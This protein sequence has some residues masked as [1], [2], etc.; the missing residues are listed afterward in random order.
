MEEPNGRVPRW[1]GALI[2]VLVVGSLVTAA[3]VL[4]ASWGQIAWGALGCLASALALEFFTWL[5]TGGPLRLE[6]RPVRD[7]GRP[8]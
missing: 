8:E 3:R 5:V 2:A 6:K 7:E 4:G 1:V